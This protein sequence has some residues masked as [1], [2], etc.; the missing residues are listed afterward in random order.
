MRYELNLDRSGDPNKKGDRDEF[1][2]IPVGERRSTVSHLCDG[3]PIAES[4]SFQAMLSLGIRDEIGIPARPGG[5][6]LSR[7][8]SSLAGWLLRNTPPEKLQAEACAI[9]KKN[10]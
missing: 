8:W 5:P 7:E 10:R 2:V 4:H 9:L 1:I 6:T 3:D